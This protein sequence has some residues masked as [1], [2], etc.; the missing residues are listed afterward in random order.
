MRKILVTGFDPFGGESINPAYE[1]VKLL[2]EQI[3]DAR[4][5]PLE[6]P[7]VFDSG[8]K[9]VI[10]AVSELQPDFVL[11][12]GQA[13]GRSQITPEFVGINY[14]QARIPDNEGNQPLNVPLVPGAPAAYFTQLP[15][16]A[17]VEKIK[18]KGLPAAVSYT[19]GTY[20]CNAMMYSVL[21]ALNTAFPHIRGGFMHVPYATE[22]TVNQPAGTPGMNLRDIAAGI[23]AGIEAILENERDITAEGRDALMFEVERLTQAVRA[24][25][26]TMSTS[27]ETLFADL[28]ALGRRYA[29]IK[30]SIQHLQTPVHTLV[31]S[32]DQKIFMGDVTTGENRA[33][34][35]FHLESGQLVVKVPVP[36]R[37]QAALPA[38]AARIRK[39]FYQDWLP[40]QPYESG[41]WKDVEVYHYRQRYFRKSVKM[42]MELWF[43]LSP[44]S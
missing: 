30:P 44:K 35:Q 40:D 41:E 25:G 22:Q 14:A 18:A 23:E 15:V 20:V 9:K 27:E 29:K 37:L 39:A 24:S 17:M 11:C 19:A 6:V 5:I 21:H 34:D 43:C 4:V 3:L 7:T 36:Y 31:A 12:I 8:P 26:V 38:K 2:P 16:Y 33:L 10:E 13:G 28:Q 42:V 1:A 32:S